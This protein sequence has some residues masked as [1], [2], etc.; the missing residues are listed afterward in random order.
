MSSRDSLT[1]V[2]PSLND[3]KTISA[4]VNDCLRY[5]PVKPK[6]LVVLDTKTS[7]D[8]SNFAKKA[9]AEVIHIGK[10]K[11]KGYAFRNAIPHVQSKYLIQIDSDYQFLPKDLK[12]IFKPLQNGYD[13]SLGTRYQTGSKVEKGS[14]SILKY[15]GSLFLS[16]I[17]SLLIG[18]KITD[19]MA[20]F[21]GFKTDSLKKIKLT[22]DHF[23]YEAEVIIK[24]SQKGMSITNVPIGYKKRAAGNSSLSSFKD[25]YLV[26]KTI[27]KS[28]RKKT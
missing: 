18:V 11:G 19:V 9:G 17:T 26:L 13:L 8:T 5:S 2:I 21:K 3:E 23:G 27:L 14:V 25:G 10:G 15:L 7:D 16:T 1:I 20:G 24:A 28:V 4:I 12:K 22:T 6:I